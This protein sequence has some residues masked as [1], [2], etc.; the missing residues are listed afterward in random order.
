MKHII[1]ILIISI[2]IPF[3]LQAQFDLGKVLNSSKDGSNQLNEKDASLGIKELLYKGVKEAVKLSSKEDGYLNNSLIKIPFPKE[4][5]KVESTLRNLGFNELAD[6]VIKSFNRAAEKAAVKAQPIFIGA[7]QQLTLNDAIALV[8]SDDNAATNYLKGK[9]NNQLISAFKP[10]IH[11]SLKSVKATQYWALAI[12]QY[13]KI[14]FVTKVE[15]D[16]D[17]YVTEQAVSGLFVMLAQEEKKIR[18]D[19]KARTSE[20]LKK[21]FK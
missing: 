4:A 8:K 19:P 9:T 13:N 5:Q 16:L 17:Q 21:I 14:P 7:V 6:N 1:F 15:L 3:N 20:L 11:A 2:C 10:D 18:I 12:E